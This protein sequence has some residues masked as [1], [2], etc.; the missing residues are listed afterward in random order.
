MTTP[1]EKETYVMSWCVQ[2]ADACQLI[3]LQ[4]TPTKIGKKSLIT[5]FI[6]KHLGKLADQEEGDQGLSTILL[7]FDYIVI[8]PPSATETADQDSVN[9]PHD[10]VSQLTSNLLN[11]QHWSMSSTLK[12]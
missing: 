10:D 12:T 3:G 8:D 7:L 9:P 1:D 5:K 11:R 4:V 2:D 6:M